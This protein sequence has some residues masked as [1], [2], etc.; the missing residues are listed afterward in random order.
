MQPISVALFGS[1]SKTMVNFESLVMGYENDSLDEGNKSYI[2]SSFLL[3]LLLL[4][5]LLV[6]RRNFR[7]LLYRFGLP[8]HDPT[9]LAP[10]GA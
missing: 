6:C 10:L 9:E 4:A 1:H 2:G 7:L 3:L 5:L 8:K